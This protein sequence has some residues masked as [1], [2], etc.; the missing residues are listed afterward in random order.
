MADLRDWWQRHTVSRFSLDEELRTRSPVAR[1]GEV[2][3]HVALIL[4]LIEPVLVM[5][6]TTL[7][8][9]LGAAHPAMG[10][11][12]GGSIFGDSD[13]TVGNGVRE[14]IRWARN[15]LFLLGVGGCAWGALNVMMEKPY[16]KQFIGGGACMG[17]GAI[18]SLAHSFSQGNAVNVD[19]D[20]GQ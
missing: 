3:V 15:I 16:T 20:L 7:V 12:P 5:G 9:L 14:A 13:Q 10:Q 6:V 17:F 1:I 2:S 11:T 4:R 19:T 18:A 8:L